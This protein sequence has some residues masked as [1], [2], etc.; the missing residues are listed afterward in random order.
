MTE[1]PPT[2]AHQ[3]ER[4]A[5]STLQRPSAALLRRFAIW[6]VGDDTIRH[7]LEKGFSL[8][9]CCRACPRTIEWTPPE[10]HHR[11]AANLDLR[12][13]DLVPRLSC[14]G[15]GGCGSTDIAVFPHLFDGAW[16]WPPVELA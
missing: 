1:A 3:D 7:Y 16:R 8:G 6:Q 14:K 5:A 9:M 15:D 2:G 12:L 13:A 11:F 4:Q 10:L